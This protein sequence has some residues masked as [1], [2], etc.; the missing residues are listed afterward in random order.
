MCKKFS[1][2]TSVLCS[3]HVFLLGPESLLH[4]I[5]FKPHKVLF[6]SKVISDQSSV[7]K[8]QEIK[9]I[10][11]HSVRENFKEKT[12]TTANGPQ[13]DSADVEEWSKSK[14]HQKVILNVISPQ[15][16]DIYRTTLQIKTRHI[17][18]FLLDLRTSN[19]V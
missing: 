17:S 18:E 13:E 9:N 15:R 11:I 6:C 4:I 1:W 2:C 10:F 19:V 3:Q 16:C 14:G 7:I 12:H 8:L 5:L